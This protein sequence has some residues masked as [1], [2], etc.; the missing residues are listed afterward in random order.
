M[1]SQTHGSSDTVSVAKLG[2][3]GTIGTAIISA[4]TTAVVGLI[5]YNDQI[6]RAHV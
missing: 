3:Y 4:I 6:G 1:A 5:N 2:L